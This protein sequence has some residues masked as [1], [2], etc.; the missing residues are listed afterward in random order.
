[1]VTNFKAFFGN[2]KGSIDVAAVVKSL[3]EPI[4]DAANAA[5]KETHEGRETLGSLLSRRHSGDTIAASAVMKPNETSTG[6]ARSATTKVAGVDYPSLVVDSTGDYIFGWKNQVYILE[7]AKVTK[8]RVDE[9]LASSWEMFLMNAQIQEGLNKPAPSSEEGKVELEVKMKEELLHAVSSI[10]PEPPTEI[11]KVVTEV[12]AKND[13][14]TSSASDQALNSALNQAFKNAAKRRK[15][16]I[17][18]LTSLRGD[19]QH[20]VRGKKRK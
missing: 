6:D 13:Q 20:I 7:K 11:K 12:V 18:E 4:L 19:V 9:I 14:P 10:T 2:K 15:L 3:Y 5:S 1:M 16:S 17:D 8:E